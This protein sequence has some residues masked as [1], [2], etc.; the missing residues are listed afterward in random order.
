MN[1]FIIRCAITYLNAIEAQHYYKLTPHN[2]ILIILYRPDDRLDTE[3][4][5]KMIDPSLWKAINFLPYNVQALIS[6]K[7]PDYN[8]KSFF[9]SKTVKFFYVYK[10]IR[11]LNSAIKKNEPV[12]KVFV[13]DYNIPSMRHLT[14][15]LRP[16]EIINLDEGAKVSMI[17]RKRAKSDRKSFQPV[18]RKNFWKDK[19]SSLLFGYKM[20][21]LKN[22]SFF[23]AWDLGWFETSNNIKVDRNNFEKLKTGLKTLKKDSCILFAGQSLSEVNYMDE[24][25]YLD[26]LAAV[27]NWFG[28]KKIIYVTHRGDHPSK[29]EKIKKKIGLKVI[30]LDLPIEYQLCL[31]GPIPEAVA[32]FNSSS[33]QNLDNIAGGLINIF[34]FYIHP[35]H[36]RPDRRLIAHEYFEYLAL[37]TSE[38]FKVVHLKSEDIKTA[39]RSGK[40]LC[41]N[42]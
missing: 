9:Y 37:A 19:M 6:E 27:K 16:H 17:Y 8:H 23:S 39:S 30:S 13:G 28:G 5:V 26:Y 3:H 29:L 2:S 20:S 14:N 12:E 1:Y 41:H 22:V 25:V 24:D 40:K 18:M 42:E 33:L 4:I 11:R 36:I 10:F 32:S 34:S 7:I 35:E 38:S 21:A 31:K 15:Q